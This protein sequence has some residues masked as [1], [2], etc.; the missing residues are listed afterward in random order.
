[1]PI[2]LI[3]RILYVR[4]IMALE[5]RISIALVGNGGMQRMIVIERD[6]LARWVRV[7]KQRQDS[8]NR[9]YYTGYVSAMSTVEGMMAMCPGY[10]LGKL[11]DVPHP[12]LFTPEEVCM[13]MVEHGQGNLERFAW[14]EKIVY[15]PSEV[16]RLLK[17]ELPKG[18]EV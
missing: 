9:D 1:M 12:G 13:K 6:F 18:K 16:M 15:S 11:A 8:G 4:C 5:G 14:G 17:G 3:R 2:I 10:D 7:M